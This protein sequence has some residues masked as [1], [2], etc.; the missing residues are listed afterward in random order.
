MQAEPKKIATLSEGAYFGEIAILDRCI[1]PQRADEGFESKERRKNKERRTSFHVGNGLL[2]SGGADPEASQAVATE[3]PPLLPDKQAFLRTA[4]VKATSECELLTLKDVDLASV[5]TIFPKIRDELY[6]TA[7]ER[8][9]QTQA[10]VAKT[11]KGCALSA[12]EGTRDLPGAQPACAA[13][14]CCP[15]GPQASVDFRHKANGSEPDTSGA[16]STSAYGPRQRLANALRQMEAAQ[17]E[18]HKLQQA[19]MQAL[20]V[21][22]EDLLPRDGASNLGLPSHAMLSHFDH[23]PA[24]ASCDSTEYHSSDHSQ[25]SSALPGRPRN[26]SNRRR[27]SRHETSSSPM[28][29]IEDT[30]PEPANENVKDGRGSDWL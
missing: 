20:R 13:G 4:S 1:L 25:N 8:L 21:A 12:N 2:G 30:Q 7:R 29:P 24:F 28:L 17:L 9:A 3:P 11:D 5:L 22:L 14:A 18:Q 15:L 16:A 23:S 19:H 10:L 26:R 6:A 27:I